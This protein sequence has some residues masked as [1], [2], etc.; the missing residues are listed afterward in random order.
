[1][2]LKESSYLFIASFFNNTLVGNKLLQI[3]NFVPNNSTS[4][5]FFNFSTV[6]KKIY[7]SY[8]LK[9]VLVVAG[10]KN[11]YDEKSITF[12]AHTNV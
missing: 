9:Q 11:I 4:L 8:Y 10:K 1:M 5:A 6:Q 7:W 12:I 3:R 2:V